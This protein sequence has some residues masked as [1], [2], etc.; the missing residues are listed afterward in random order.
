MTFFVYVIQS[1]TLSDAQ[2]LRFT[3]ETAPFNKQAYA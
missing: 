3:F 1:I 2:R